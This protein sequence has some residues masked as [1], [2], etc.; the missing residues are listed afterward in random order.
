MKSYLFILMIGASLFSIA[1]GG[2]GTP[3]TTKTAPPTYT[4][5]GSVSGLTGTG[6]VLQ[7]NSGDN[8]TVKA[9]ATSFTFATAI[10]SGSAYKV[11]VMT[12][13]A[14]QIRSVTGGSGTATVQ[15]ACTNTIGGTISG[16]VGTGLVLQDNGGDNLTVKANATSFTFATPISGGASYKVSVL[17]QPSSPVQTCVVSAGSGTAAA[18]NVTSVS[19]ACT[20]VTYTIGGTI[21]GLVG[22][23]LT[24]LDNGGDSLTVAAN[25]TS[26]TFA[27]ALDSGATYGVTV[28]AQP[29]SPVQNCVVNSGTGTATANVTSVSIVCTTVTYTI[30]GTV[31]GLAG[32]GLVLQDNGGNN[33]TVT[34]NGPFT[35]TTQLNSITTYSVTVLTQPVSPIQN[36]VVG[37]GSGTPTAN[38]TNVSVACTSTYTVSGTISGLTAKGLV[39]QD[40]GGDNLAVTPNQTAFAFLTPV[41]D[42]TAYSVTVFSQPNIPAQSCSVTTGTG[43][44]TSSVNVTSVAIT[45]ADV[46]Q[47]TWENGSDLVNQA[48]IYPSSTGSVG[49][50]G[51]RYSGLSWSDKAGNFWLLGGY[52]YG[53]AGPAADLNDLW[54]YNGTAATWTWVAGANVAGAP[55]I[56][57]TL[58]T[59]AT[60][61]I[62]GARDSGVSWTDA[63]GNFWLFGGHGYD[64][65]KTADD[66]N[67]LWMYNPTGCSNPTGCWTWV[68][69]SDIVDQIGTYGAT[70][71]TP[72]TP[73]ARYSAVSWIDSK[74]NF[75][76]FGGL[77]YDSTGT[78]GSLNDLW[79]GNY[80]SS[81]QWVWTWVSGSNIAGTK[82]TYGS[83]GKDSPSNTPGARYLSS[84]WTDSEGNL[85]LFGGYGPDSV[86]NTAALNDLWEFNTT[87]GQWAWIGGSEYADQMGTYGSTTGTVGIP[88]SRKGAVAWTDPNGNFWVFGGVG[89]DSTG[90]SGELNDLWEYNATTSQWTWQSGSAFI[91]GLGIYGTLG[92]ESPTNVP[93]A[94][95]VSETWTDP[96]GNLWLFGGNG[97][98]SGTNGSFNDLWKFVP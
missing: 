51:G 93:G 97:P 38:V 60:T 21:S 75:W 80:N 63:S 53:S 34:G 86:G 22:T 20:T 44:G 58:G 54:E 94:R 78:V 81:N 57:G 31:S 12:Q 74:G 85:W 84:S 1:C 2:G 23:G 16:L 90:V 49:T 66:L 70:V 26:F 6:L 56:Y 9:G 37:A 52:G 88:G 68:S 25:K 5:G 14:N 69:G 59:A 17:T 72:G 42:G 64:S 3:G 96:S 27:T 55:G 71:N 11:S 39:L 35:F 62:P 19:I 73:G 45:C 30:G 36:C 82:G 50:P 67:D 32:S 95:G 89:V 8:L 92:M 98:S 61:N 28:T 10:A 29:S 41:N 47:W 15:I 83:I 7:N 46:N 65:A 79:E 87:L 77:G 43:S 33:L 40:N 24:L 76:L 91:D 48:G 4:I 13:P 18:G